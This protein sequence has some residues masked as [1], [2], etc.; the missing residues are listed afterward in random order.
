MAGTGIINGQQIPTGTQGKLYYGGA[1][2]QHY[3]A[4]SRGTMQASNHLAPSNNMNGPSMTGNTALGMSAQKPTG[5][6]G[7]GDQYNSQNKRGSEFKKSAQH[8]LN[9]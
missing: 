6:A 2:G 8:I 7:I 4:P 5:G 1:N 3:E 9:R